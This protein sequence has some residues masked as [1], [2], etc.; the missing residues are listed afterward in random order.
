MKKNTDN[1]RI[2]SVKELAAYLGVS[3]STARMIRKDI[4]SYYKKKYLTLNL[5]KKYFDD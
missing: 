2:I 5:I 1:L 3:Y 4:L